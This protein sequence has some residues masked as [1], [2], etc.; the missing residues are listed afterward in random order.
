MG[1]KFYVAFVDFS[2][3]FDSALHETCLDNIRNQ[4]TEG[5]FALL[6]LRITHYFFLLFFVYGP[7]VSTLS[8][9]SVLLVFIK[10]V[11]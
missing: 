11:C 7:A 9:S 6:G 2:K 3:V 1:Q 10:D 8:F 5:S 4:G